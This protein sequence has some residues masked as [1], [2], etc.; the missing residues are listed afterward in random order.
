MLHSRPTCSRD[1][2]R[3]TMPASE[4]ASGCRGHM[5]A[6][7]HDAEVNSCRI[8]TIVTRSSSAANEQES[9]QGQLHAA[10]AHLRGGVLL[11]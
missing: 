7:H 1:T 5:L 11:G 3:Q 9:H 4:Q 2:G 6:G 8:A 10:I